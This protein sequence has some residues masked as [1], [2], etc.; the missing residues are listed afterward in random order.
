V[1]YLDINAASQLDDRV[2]RCVTRVLSYGFGNAASRDHAFGWDAAQAV[3]RA[4][5]DL[6]ELVGARPHEIVFTGSATESINLAL[7][8]VSVGTIVASRADHEAV[9]GVCRQLEGRGACKT[10][11]LEV[12][13]G[14]QVDPRALDA[15]L[16]EADPPVLVALI[17]AN[18]EIGA[19]NPIRE[20]ADVAHA[21]GALFFS[22][23]TQAVGRI[24]VDFEALGVDLAAFSAHKM[25]GPKG[26]G[27]LYIRGGRER[28]ALE[29]L[30][31]GG[32]QER[33]IRAGTLNV[34]AIVGF[35]EACRIA[36]MEMPEESK[37]IAALRDRLE[38][39]LLTRLDDVF[40][41]GD[42]EHRLP[43][44]TN[45]CFRGVDA[46]ALLRDVYVVAASTKSACSS[47]DPGPSHVL[48]AI[49]LSDDDAYASVR[50]SLGRFNTREE[51]DQ[52]GEKIV[53][54]VRKLRAIRGR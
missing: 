43:N 38:Q 49:G 15:V 17:H 16:G 50:F 25:H 42:T 52:A 27:A 33:G 24:R 18:N 22:D 23:S 54:S 12:D 30:I 6:A 40:V 37:R 39:T 53:A 2:V 19:I 5:L 29:P 11:W 46:R 26:V 8:G 32:G 31:V 21:H 45:L 36:E 10:R 7:K 51:I 9:R 35:G 4:R 1:P 14:G 44:T 20:L 34:P 13:R 48:K 41:S 47:G 28:I 3:E